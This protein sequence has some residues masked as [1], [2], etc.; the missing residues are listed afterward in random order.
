[1][2]RTIASLMFVGLLST[3]AAF[4]QEMGPTPATPAPE[5]S[6]VTPPAATQSTT[7]STTTTTSTDKMSKHEAMKNCVAREQSGNSSMSKSDA[8]KAC[9]D[10]IKA[11]KDAGA[12]P[13]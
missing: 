1:M 10:A 2:K 7:T 9:H 12:Q 5:Q 4:A 3:G 8:K 13:Q 6:A 11:Q